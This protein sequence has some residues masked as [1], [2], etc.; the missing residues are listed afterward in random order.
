MK[1]T[2]DI[3]QKYKSKN[4]SALL[5]IA[6][7]WFNLYIRLRDRDE[8]GYALCISSGQRVK[9]GTTNYQSGHYISRGACPELMFE[10]NNVHVQGKSD[11]YFKSGNLI[12]YRINLIKKIGEDAVL[13]LEKRA[14]LYK[15]NGFK[16]DR[17]RLIEVIETYKEKCKNYDY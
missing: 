4:V 3:I 13:D 16:H 10:E 7:K 9:Y 11:N 17:F 2:S 1:L 5:K 12:E 15:R 8:W 6:T 14:A